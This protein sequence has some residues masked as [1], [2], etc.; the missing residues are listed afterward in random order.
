VHAPR[1]PAHAGE[2]V[3]CGLA[4]ARVSFCFMLAYCR[5]C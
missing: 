3:C 5:E 1:R 4:E 2:P